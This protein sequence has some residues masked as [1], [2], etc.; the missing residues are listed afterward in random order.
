MTCFKAKSRLT[1]ILFARTLRSLNL[2][3]SLEAVQQPTTLPPSLLYKAEDVRAS[4][5]VTKLNTMM[6]D[7]RKVSQVNQRLL[8]EVS[9]SSLV[10]P[11]FFVDISIYKGMSILRSEETEDNALRAQYGTDRW[12]RQ[13]SRIAHSQ[14]IARVEHFGTILQDAIQ[15]DGVVRAKYGE[16]AELIDLLGGDEVRSF[17]LKDLRCDTK[18]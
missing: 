11:R 6:Q 3:A 13:P 9:L 17:S 10:F 12:I 18:Y 5:G 14:L 8:D 4:R 15:S 1:T 7:V 2:P 16:W